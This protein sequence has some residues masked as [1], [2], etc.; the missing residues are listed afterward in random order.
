MSYRAIL[1]GYVARVAQPRFVGA[2]RFDGIV[3]VNEAPFCQGSSIRAPLLSACACRI[4]QFRRIVGFGSDGALNC[5][6]TTGSAPQQIP[7][8]QKGG[9]T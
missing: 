1:G 2:L 5:R 6:D 3:G 4:R 9:A 8:S 7:V